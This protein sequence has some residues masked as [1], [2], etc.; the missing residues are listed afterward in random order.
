MS[1]WWEHETDEHGDFKYTLRQY[2]LMRRLALGGDW[3]D[4][5]TA[6]NAEISRN[7]GEWDV[8][9]TDTYRN[10]QAWYYGGKPAGPIDVG[11][12]SA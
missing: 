11:S 7:V 12:V 1:E 9:A 3:T 10:W 5:V 2:L 4:V 8:E 6:V